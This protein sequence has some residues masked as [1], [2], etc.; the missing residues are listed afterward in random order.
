[1]LQK[2]IIT[3]VDFCIRYAMQVIGIAGLFALVCGI[4]AASHFA[5]DADA[6]KLVSKD[7]PWRQR[8]ATFDSYFPS[9]YEIILAVVDAPTS[10]LASQAS[11]A[12]VAKLSQ[13]KDL[14]H[15]VSEAA[16]GPFFEKNGL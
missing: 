10:E 7:L 5:L 8:E 9:K 2:A 15:S 4:Y 12:L 1:M 13:Q 3:T 11:T 14:F 6:N 16:G